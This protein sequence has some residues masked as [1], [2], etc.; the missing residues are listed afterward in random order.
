MTMARPVA[1]TFEGGLELR[2]GEAERY[3]AL[4]LERGWSKVGG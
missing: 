2:L 4:G 1:A 3:E